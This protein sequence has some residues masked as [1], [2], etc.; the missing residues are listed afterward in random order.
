[1]EYGVNQ[2]ECLCHILFNCQESGICTIIKFIN[3]TFNEK[4]TSKNRSRENIKMEYFY[5]FDKTIVKE[6]TIR[7]WSKSK[8]EFNDDKNAFLYESKNRDMIETAVQDVGKNDEQHRIEI[9]P[10]TRIE[11]LLEF[12]K[13]IEGED[14]NKNERRNGEQYNGRR[15]SNK[16]SNYISRNN[17]F[18][19]N[20]TCKKRTFLYAY[21]N[22]N[23]FIH[24]KRILQKFGNRC[25]GK[26][27]TS[28][29]LWN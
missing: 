24:K 12:C 18:T 16:L 4:Y 17:W 6:D 8:E 23:T 3:D 10:V 2:E 29:C 27:D 5:D 20:N 22:L 26:A 25:Y 1:M 21:G 11:E 9:V 13:R 14:N 28:D 19:T 7:I 15:K